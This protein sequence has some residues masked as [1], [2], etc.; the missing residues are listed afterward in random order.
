MVGRILNIAWKDMLHLWH[1]RALLLMVILG[2]AS[3]LLLVGWATGAEV[4]DLKTVVID[5]DQTQ[6]SQGLIEELGATSTLTLNEGA[7]DDFTKHDNRSAALDAIFTGG[8]FIFNPDNVLLVEIPDGFGA[9]L[10]AGEHPEVSLTLN[11]AN[12]VG[13]TTAR[14]AAED[15]LYTYGAI[16]Q[17]QNT[18]EQAGLNP[19]TADQIVARLENNQPDV[20]VRYNEKLDRAAYTTPSEA[21]FVLYIIA[22]MVAAFML[23]REREYGTFEQLLVMPQRPIEIIIGKAIPALL[24][25]YANFILVL[26]EMNVVFDIPVRGSLLLLLVLAVG[27]LFVELGRGFLV[28]MISRTQNQALLI[29]MLIA[30]VDITFAGYAVPV[31]SMPQIMQ[32]LSNLF[33]IRHWMIILRGILQ[34]DVGLDVLWPQL[35]WLAALG[36]IINSITLWFFRRSLAEQK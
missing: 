21:A 36:L 8:N 7:V 13:S 27:Y 10:A 11:G 31:E 29:V 28:A 25:G 3:E 2:A 35:V 32:T 9:Q 24:V 19:P 33:P 22:I 6:I 15:V 17:T 1:N 18:M 20:T 30:F 26:V 34:K 16:V 5:H 23:A 4:D 12:S 14:R